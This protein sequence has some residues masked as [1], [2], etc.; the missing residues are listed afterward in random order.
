MKKFLLLLVFGVSF[1]IYAEEPAP[2]SV[3]LVIPPLVVEFENKSEQVMDIQVPDYGDIILPEFEISLPDPGDIPINDI[4]FNIPLPDFT[5]YSYSVKPSFFSEGILGIG[6]HNHLIGNI[7]LFRLGQDFRFSLSFVHDGLD[8]FGRNDAGMGYFSRSEIFRGNFNNGDKSF[9]LTGSG[10][11]KEIED[12]LQGQVSSY[13]SV[14]HRLSSVNLGVSGGDKISWKGSAAVNSAGK[15]LTGETPIASNESLAA[16]YSSFS[17]KRGLFSSTLSTGYKYNKQS[18]F[19]EK[20]ILNS[21]LKFGITLKSME[22]FAS[23]GVFWIPGTSPLYPYSI[24]VDGAYEEKIQYHS[25]IGYLVKNYLNYDTW[26]NYSYFAIASGLDK[27]WFWNNK[28]TISPNQ[29]T[30]IG[31]NSLYRNMESYMSFI[32]GSFNSSNGLF[33]VE[34][35]SGSYLDFSPFFKV[36]FHSGWNFSFAWDGQL[37][38]DEDILKPVHSLSSEVVY[39]KENTGFSLSGIYSLKPFLA[40]PSLSVEVHYLISDGI[41]LSLEGK[42]VFGYFSEERISFGNYVQDGAKLTLLTKISL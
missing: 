31:L 37:F 20:N 39:E 6:D 5:E 9:M 14:I 7:S 36:S 15:T 22:I 11:F 3:E 27:G 40:V 23:A 18:E 13:S 42:D 16:L 26:E 38:F 35:I 25:S 30:E 17:F 4:T 19:P 34:N 41:I 8:G 33:S 12:G 10:S 1:I 2:S 29:Y 21:D 28:A 32:P 24:T